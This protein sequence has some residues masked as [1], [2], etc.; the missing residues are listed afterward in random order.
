MKKTTP[1]F[2]TWF[3]GMFWK[4]SAVESGLRFGVYDSLKGDKAYGIE[5]EFGIITSEGKEHQKCLRF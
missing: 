3:D 2:T 1:R 4:R 5:K